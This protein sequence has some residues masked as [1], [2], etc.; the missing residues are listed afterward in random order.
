MIVQCPLLEEVELGSF[1]CGGSEND[2]EKTWSVPGW[3]DGLNCRH[4][5]NTQIQKMGYGCC[6]ARLL[7][8]NQEPKNSTFCVYRYTSDVV[9]GSENRK[10]VLC[11]GIEIKQYSKVGVKHWAK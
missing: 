9:S 8:T 4:E 3:N 5:C 1:K 11:K 7:T 2:L 10:A 6:E